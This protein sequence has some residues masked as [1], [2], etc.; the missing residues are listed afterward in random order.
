VG[1]FFA[2]LKRRKVPR[3]AVTYLVAAWGISVGAAE[4]LPLLGGQEWFVRGIVFLS[5]AGFPIV[6][7]LSWKYE[8]TS[9]GLI[10][11]QP[12]APEQGAHPQAGHGSGQG[13][14]ESAA[15]YDPANTTTAVIA[16]KQQRLWVEWESGRQHRRE[17]FDGPFT[18]GRDPN[19]DVFVD[20]KAV[21]RRHGIVLFE[22]NRWVI[23]DLGSR[24]GIFIDGEQLRG[25]RALVESVELWLSAD[26]PTI[27]MQLPATNLGQTTKVVHPKKRSS[28]AQ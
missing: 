23:E 24:N 17:S 6:L 22:S 20:H 10:R 8:L 19:S 13:D 7:I 16:N 21:S 4:L 26:G 2:E 5:I 25:K 9:E 11:E 14:L 27:N 3:A 18:I 28:D 1:R 15:Q 12:I